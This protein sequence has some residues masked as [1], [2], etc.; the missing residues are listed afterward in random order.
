MPPRRLIL[1]LFQSPGDILMMT[2]AVRDLQLANPGQ[3]ETDVRTATD[4]LWLHNPHITRLTEGDPN[5]QQIEMHYPLIHESN[6]RPFHFI[7]GFPQYLE[8]QLGVK[9]PVTRFCGDIHLSAD[10]R[11]APPPGADLGVPERFWIVIAGGKY[12]FTAKWWNPASFQTVVDHFRG[13]IQFVQ[14]GEAGHWH[15]PLEGVVNLVGK[16]DTRQFVRLMYHADGVLCP[17][18]FAMHLAAAVETKPGRPRHRPCAVI[19][20]G[21]EPPHWEAYPQHQFLSTV[22]ALSCCA[23]GGCWKSRCQPVGDGDAKDR[24]DVCV[25]PVQVRSDLRIPRCMHLITPEQVIQRIEIYYQGGVLHFTHNGQGNHPTNGQLVS[26]PTEPHLSN[27]ETPPQSLAGCTP[28]M[29]VLIIFRHGL[30]DAI[31]LTII[32]KHIQKYRPD[33]QVDVAALVGKHS[34]FRG[35]CRKV[36][37]LDREPTPC[38]QYSQRF[39]LDWHECHTAYADSPGTKAERCLREEFGIV[40]DPALCTYSIHRSDAAMELA[41]K[42]LEQ[43]CKVACREDARYPVVLIHYEGNTSADMKNVP[44]DI[45][46]RLCEDIVTEGYVPV[47]LDWDYRTPLADGAR[48]LCPDQRAELWHA[49]GT[50]DAESLAALIELSA[51]M[52][53]V[54]S[55]PLHVAGATTTPT[56][57]VWTRHHPLNYMSLADNVTHLVHRD[58]A[59]LIRGDRAVGEAYFKAHYNFQIYDDLEVGLRAAVRSRLQTTQE[60]LIRTRN[61]WVRT[62]MA[63]QDLVVV[64]DIFDDDS[65]A[66]DEMPMPHPVVVDVGA[67]IGCFTK[68]IHERNPLARIFAVECCPENIAAL[69]KNVGNIASVI[70]A[71]LTYEPDLAL[72]N[73]VYTNCRSTGGSTLISRDELE[74]RVLDK[75]CPAEPGKEMAGEYWADFRPIRTV[76]IEELMQEYSFDHI[77]ILKL[78]C[79]MSEFSILGKTPSLNRIGLIVGEYHGKERFQRLVADRFAGWELRILRDGELGTFWLTNPIPPLLHL[80]R[81]AQGGAFFISEAPSPPISAPIAANASAARPT[82]D[83]FCQRLAQAFHPDDLPKFDEWSPYYRRLYELACELKPQQICEIGVRAGYSALAWLTANPTAEFLGIDFDGDERIANG[84]CGR[85]RF[86]KHAESILQPFNV[87]FQLGDSHAIE[88]LPGAD[89]VYVDGD[90]TFQGCLADLRLAAKTT[91]QILVDDF[92]SSPLV[93]QACDTFTSEHPE[94]NRRYIDNGLT[95]FLL[96]QKR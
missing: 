75:Q 15:P 76:S 51:L 13:K 1:R 95:G 54:D 10:E 55:G 30:G 29:N 5:V 11:N 2:A 46:R 28:T 22:G 78:D 42:Y 74:R 92:D 80:E 73:A 71:A 84:N 68:R 93:R 94:F 87:R 91:N 39:N 57:G 89:L 38:C 88:K 23:D 49:T 34:A 96:F 4:A 61:F 59:G 32:L 45:I 9:V 77:D 27:G 18:T 19:A 43:T 20:G 35:L 81:G 33:W 66:V 37:V 60:D 48:I 52:V 25:E 47:I 50:G 72:L 65:Y 64:K 21:R 90:H 8:Q 16:T 40:P 14:C 53:G 83:E 36:Y 69:K 58:H 86:H 79:E 17:V 12:D 31:Q 26:S 24:Q 63:E 85:D 44:A 67:H 56:L 6:Q 62:E 7:H 41:R 82:V 3:F 70:Q